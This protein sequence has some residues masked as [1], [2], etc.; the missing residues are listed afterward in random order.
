MARNPDRF[1]AMDE[2]PRKNMLYKV[3]VATYN[4]LTGEATNKTYRANS[5]VEAELIERATDPT[6]AIERTVTVEP[7]VLAYMELNHPGC[8]QRLWP[9][10]H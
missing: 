1:D 4:P 5:L 8:L 7:D 9:R 6:N 10:S 3:R 2:L